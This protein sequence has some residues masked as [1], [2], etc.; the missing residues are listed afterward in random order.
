[1][2]GPEEGPKVR[3]NEAD[4]QGEALSCGRREV[5][6]QNSGS[7]WVTEPVQAAVKQRQG[8]V[9]E[10]SA[11]EVDS[12]ESNPELDSL[13]GGDFLVPLWRDHVPEWR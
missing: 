6:V 13:R 7:V 12:R 8:M 4:F 9:R 1:M 10:R 2:R 5:E 11:Q 3:S